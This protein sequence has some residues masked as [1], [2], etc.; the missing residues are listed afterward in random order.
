MYEINETHDPNLRSWVESANDPDTDFPIQNLPFCLFKQEGI[1]PQAPRGFMGIRIG[2]QLLNLD[3]A[4]SAGFFDDIFPPDEHHGHLA[5][6]YLGTLGIFLGIETK[7]RKAMR[8]RLNALLRDDTDLDKE[9]IKKF[10]VDSNSVSFN[11]PT[12]PRDYTDFYCSI[13]HATNVGSMFR[14]ENPLL[15]NYKYIPIAYHGRASSIVVS[16]TDIKRPKGQNR[17]DQEKPPLFGP[18]KN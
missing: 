14:P 13:Y 6:T 15:P 12:H 1:K 8:Q 3:Y 16:G 5:V 18:C 10:M 17:S 7:R 4:I 9:A 2:E 11:M